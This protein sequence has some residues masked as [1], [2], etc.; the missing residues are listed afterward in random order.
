MALKFLNL[1][2]KIGIFHQFVSLDQYFCAQSGSNMILF[3]NVGLKTQFP[4]PFYSL[5]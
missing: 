5:V 3:K 4:I 1:V 2:E